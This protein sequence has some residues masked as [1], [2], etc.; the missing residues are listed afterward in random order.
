MSSTRQSTIKHLKQCAKEHGV[1]TAD[2]VL[3]V[4]KTA[5][6]DAR[7][8]ISSCGGIDESAEDTNRRSSHGSSDFQDTPKM[9]TQ[10]KLQ[11]VDAELLPKK[12]GPNGAGS[13]SGNVNGK[14]KGNIAQE[15]PENSDEERLQLAQALSLSEKP[16]KGGQKKRKATRKL[17]KAERL[18]RAPIPALLLET[19]EEAKADLE[20]RL[21][22]VLGPR[23]PSDQ[24]SSCDF[25]GPTDKSLPPC[26]S[27]WRLSSSLPETDSYH[28]HIRGVFLSPSSFRKMLLSPSSRASESKRKQAAIEAA[29]DSSPVVLDG[30]HSPLEGTPPTLTLE[31]GEPMQCPDAASSRESNQIADRGC[32]RATEDHELGHHPQRGAGAS[33]TTEAVLGQ[34]A[35]ASAQGWGA[36]WSVAARE[37]NGAPITVR[38][39]AA[40]LHEVDPPSGAAMEFRAANI[41]GLGCFRSLVNCSDLADTTFIL[42]DGSTIHLHRLVVSARAASST[43]F[44]H[45][46]SG[47]NGSHRFRLVDVGREVVL[48]TLE[49]IYTGACRIKPSRQAHV[50]RFSQLLG[51]DEL[52]QLLLD[53]NGP[54]TNE[55]HSSMPRCTFCKAVSP[56]DEVVDT[57]LTSPVVM[58]IGEGMEKEQPQRRQHTERQDVVPLKR[59]APSD[60][61]GRVLRDMY[62]RGDG[63][64][65]EQDATGATTTD[66]THRIP[67]GLPISCGPS[68]N[69]GPLEVHSNDEEGGCTPLEA[70]SPENY[71]YDV[72]ASDDEFAAAFHTLSPSQGTIHSALDVVSVHKSPLTPMDAESQ[73]EADIVAVSPSPA[74]TDPSPSPSPGVSESVAGS[75]DSDVPGSPCSVASLLA[76]DDGIAPSSDFSRASA[77][78]EA[79]RATSAVSDVGEQSWVSSPGWEDDAGII[80]TGGVSEDD[81][82]SQ[83]QSQQRD[84]E[85]DLSGSDSDLP[86]AFGDQRSKAGSCAQASRQT[87]SIIDSPSPSPLARRIAAKTWHNRKS[88][89]LSQQSDSDLELGDVLQQHGVARPTTPESPRTSGKTD[90]DILQHLSSGYHCPAVADPMSHHC[91]AAT[92]AAAVGRVGEASD[93]GDI[94]IE[95]L[96]PATIRDMSV[97]E[98]RAVLRDCGM[99]HALLSR[100][101][102]L[103]AVLSLQARVEISGSQAAFPAN[104]DRPVAE[105]P[106]TMIEASDTE[107]T[108][109]VVPATQVQ[110]SSA[111]AATK[112][113]QSA[114][115]NDIAAALKS[116]REIYHKIL[117]YEVLDL[118]WLRAMLAEQGLHCRQKDLEAVLD[119]QCVT[120]QAP[121][122]QRT[123]RRR[124]KGKDTT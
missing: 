66:E 73:E 106:P 30:D 85:Q 70:Q 45:C 86:Q 19:E 11:A 116:N 60:A 65:E 89:A 87:R 82:G 56:A 4:R 81:I 52:M 23:T 92:S 46:T 84:P 38:S 63:A 28:Y 112:A 109:M 27:L 91:S 64:R 118:D 122:A 61:A 97:V 77:V 120:Y 108:T 62:D 72:D 8:E 3:L 80:I 37:A 16:M 83:Q 40:V 34:H 49:F 44:Q 124:R 69:N 68:P 93:A 55:E 90:E 31:S 14:G 7:A 17:S 88:A 39:D 48:A 94:P 15:H 12:V 24:P 33:A 78:S 75:L 57:N 53:T 18:L 111:A 47:L 67:A 79:R 9:R 13:G 25:E 50:L 54:D 26:T 117:L 123:A 5:I 76:E 20:R 107:D 36:G 119:A 22:A 51:V 58:V 21:T 98:L 96:S 59:A 29:P 103:E 121:K 113:T 105:F 99:K 74:H 10:R 102:L 71:I 35:S 32:T 6:L 110:K 43:L 114:C 115:A 104:N 101:Q 1:G 2:L 95:R 100:E 41:G 42:P